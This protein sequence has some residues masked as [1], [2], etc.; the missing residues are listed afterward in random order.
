MINLP[1]HFETKSEARSRRKNLQASRGNVPKCNKGER[2]QTEQCHKC[3]R[4]FRKSLVKNSTNLGL[5]SREQ[6]WF[7]LTLV[8]SET[9]IPI[10]K[11]ECLDLK[12][13]VRKHNVRLKRHIPDALVIG[14][15]D[16][17]LNMERGIPIGWQPHLHLMIFGINKEDS[18]NALRSVY[19]RSDI[20]KR[21][22]RHELLKEGTFNQ[23]LTYCYKSLYFEHSDRKF[24]PDRK[25]NKRNMLPRKYEEELRAYLCNWLIGDRLILRH[26]RRKPTADKTQQQLVLDALFTGE[27]KLLSSESGSTKVKRCKGAKRKGI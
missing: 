11:L 14:G 23:I 4:R 25:Y 1:E 27:F 20:A 24:I 8:P 16:I 3:L 7:C 12:N 26:A 18:L 17:S 13:E 5:H 10:G 2:C 9:L 22:I 15:I 21:P 6:D 19:P